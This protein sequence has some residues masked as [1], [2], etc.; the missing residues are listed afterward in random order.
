MRVLFFNETIKEATDALRIWN[1]LNP[2]MTTYE[3]GFSQVNVDK[4]SAI[5]PLS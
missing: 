3:K 1:L 4:L 2:D 5:T